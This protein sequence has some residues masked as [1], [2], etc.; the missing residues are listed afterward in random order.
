M[1]GAV[2]ADADKDTGVVGHAIALAANAMEVPVC[3]SITNKFPGADGI[4]GLGQGGSG[5]DGAE[6]LALECFFDCDAVCSSTAPVLRFRGFEVLGVLGPCTVAAVGTIA[7]L[8][9]MLETPGGGTFANC[10]QICTILRA[11]AAFAGSVS[12]KDVIK[13]LI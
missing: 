9:G 10:C 11:S 13:E 6:D 8:A 12:S 1:Q 2:G 5:A 4:S 3:E 7:A